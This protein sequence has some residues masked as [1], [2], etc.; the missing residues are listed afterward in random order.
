MKI[1]CYIVFLHFLLFS[2][3]QAAAA[4]PSPERTVS[5]DP[6]RM[7]IDNVLIETVSNIRG[8][9]TVVKTIV[10][11]AGPLAEEIS[12][13]FILTAGHVIGNASAV[14]VIKDGHEYPAKVICRSARPDVALLCVDVKLHSAELALSYLPTRLDDIY[15]ASCPS[16]APYTWVI[17]GTVGCPKLNVKANGCEQFGLIGV[18]CTAQPG[19]SGGGVYDARGRMIGIFTIHLGNDSL[20]A[21]VPLND[22]YKLIPK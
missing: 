13:S 5:A 16:G 4:K 17:R 10:V 7:A 8:S 21:F 1:G 14:I 20:G 18:N 3:S 9:G 19:M 11:P 12:Q 22:F 6:D 2:F 15:V